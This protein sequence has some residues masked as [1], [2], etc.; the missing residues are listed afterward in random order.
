MFNAF[1]TKKSNC[2]NIFQEKI[3][4]YRMFKKIAKKNITSSNSIF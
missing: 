2:I 1:Y 4:K 3:L